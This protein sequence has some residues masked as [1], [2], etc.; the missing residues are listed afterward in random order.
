M[1]D[2]GGINSV[3]ES[4]V[5]GCDLEMPTSPKWRGPKAL[6]AV[7]DGKLSKEAVETAAANI[8]YLIERTKGFDMSAELPEREDDRPETRKLIRELGSEGLTLLKNEGNVL[9]IRSS[10]K[11]IA[12]IGP[13]VNR[14][15]AGGGGSASLHAYYHT[16]P[17]DSIKAVPGKKVTYSLGCHTYKWLPLAAEYC[18]TAAGEPGV[19]LEFFVGD[20]FE[21]EPIVIQ[22]RTNTDLFLWDSVPLEATSVWSCHCKTR[23]TPRTSG[24]HT[25]SFSSVGPG[26]LRVNGK[27]MMDL[28]DWTEQ[29][30][31]M[32]DGSKDFLFEV[33]ME[34]GVP[35]ELVAEINNEVRP[36][37]RQ[38][39][40]N[41]T[42]QNG[43]CRI[44][45]KEEDKQDYLQ[46]A[47]DA[48]KAADVAV[49]I[50]G[51]DEEWESEGY[52]RMSM[53]CT[54]PSDRSILWFVHFASMSFL[55]VSGTRQ[56]KWALISGIATKTPT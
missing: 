15:I 20:K 32:F 5:E 53:D 37:S 26:R 55:N 12:V 13:N 18:T 48:A 41:L 54:K 2:W 6:Q 44:G 35:V 45:Y 28:W 36:A 4:I 52:D 8:L 21:G 51:L 1:S 30:E 56:S 27:V 17:L 34:A 16:V 33:D 50:V 47:V 23:I 29:G 42:H 38:K 31:A 11:H 43:G 40:V 22:H 46:E 49:V 24:R 19:D 14:A 9:P 25:I 3:V 7:L 39:T 10:Q